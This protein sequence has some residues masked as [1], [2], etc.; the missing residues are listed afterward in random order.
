MK[1]K[2]LQEFLYFITHNKSLT[3]VQQKKRDAL[4]ARDYLKL[5]QG[6]GDNTS[7]QISTDKGQESKE[8]NE[9]TKLKNE[10]EIATAIKHRTGIPDD[11]EYICPKNLQ[12]FLRDFNQDDVLKYTCHLLDSKE[13]IENILKECNVEKYS[14]L[15]HLKLIRKHFRDL[16][17]KYKE[18][19]IQL[20]RY[21]V[22]LISVYL[23]DADFYG[24]KID[25][26]GKK[27]SWSANNI[28]ITW[29]C[30]DIIKWANDNPGIIPNPGDNIATQQENSGYILPRRFRSKI[31]GTPIKS[32]S[33]LTLFFK[34]LFHIRYD[35]S[36]QSILTVVNNQWNPKDVQISFSDKQFN[37]SVELLTDVDKLIQAYKGIIDLCIK[38][39]DK[40]KGPILIELSFY[41]DLESDSTFLVIHHVNSV[42]KKTSKNSI[43]RIGTQ[44]SPI[45]S[46]F[47]N[48]LCDLYIEALFSDGRCGRINLWDKNDKFEYTPL[49]EQITGVKYILK[50]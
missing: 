5:S 2:E 44:Q 45:I 49:K 30:D 18:N 34:S 11:V 42:Y 29:A 14:F 27:I 7:E 46:K 39:R 16:T 40:N 28:E 24:H 43:E 19:S 13:D 8:T 37:N 47:I 4:F 1:Q 10:Q 38:N 12:H 48:G 9:E 33:E 6:Y 21:M 25:K 36:L 3:R 31:T 15:L 32:F 35:N 20:S 50:F 41:D 17:W 23:T 26:D 22:T